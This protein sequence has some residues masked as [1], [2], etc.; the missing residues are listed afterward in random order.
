MDKE[1]MLEEVDWRGVPSPCYVLH[2]GML[3]F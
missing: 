1:R 3:L 2:E